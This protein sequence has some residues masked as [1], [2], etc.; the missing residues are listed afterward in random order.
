M[1]S[2]PL[3]TNLQKSEDKPS[4][5][6]VSSQA[7]S[8]KDS[9]EGG[10]EK[11]A[12]GLAH[13]VH[14][15]KVPKKM[16][17]IEEQFSICSFNVNSINARLPNF[18]VFLQN[19]SPDIILLQEIKCEEAK[20]PYD[21]MEE[22]GYNIEIVGQKT[23][24]GVAIISKF[25]I[26]IEARYLPILPNNSS[27]N[28]HGNPQGNLK[29]NLLENPQEN[30]PL[31]NLSPAD[32]NHHH[33]NNVSH[34]DTNSQDP[35]ARYIEAI[36]TIKDFA[37]RVASVYVPNGQDVASDKFQYKMNFFARLNRH[38]Q[39]I[40]K[41]NEILIIGGDYNVAHQEIDVYEP[42]KLAG[43]ICFHRDERMAFNSLLNL[44]LIDSFRA[45]APDLQ[46][47]TWWDYRGGAYNY[48]KG[49]RIDYLLCSP[50]ASD[51]LIKT[52]IIEEERAKKKASD[53]CPI[54]SY[55]TM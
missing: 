20:F 11:Q 38:L 23:F 17:K 50:Q 7:S 28:I 21:E 34:Q 12:S 36:I 51:R 4:Q 2:L 41:H 42:R 32:A 31:Q 14:G 52:E 48:N 37:I 10:L 30:H 6:M 22:F 35:Q 45:L 49:M 1:C 47:F 9:K 8:S 13:E 44:G 53:H 39:N 29:E 26:E 54:I 55:F 27:K 18:K 19:H 33:N 46:K 15:G 3:F 43:K 24:N 16:Q 25:P 5:K 40:I